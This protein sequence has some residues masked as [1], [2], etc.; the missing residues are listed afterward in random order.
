M[1]ITDLIPWRKRERRNIPVRVKQQQPTRTLQQ[2]F[3][4]L[5]DDLL[6]QFGLTPFGELETGVSAF[7]PRVDIVEDEKAIQVSVELPGV[8]EDDIDVA[9]SDDML[10]ISGEKR[11]EKE[12]R[13][14]SYYQLERS[15]GSFQR[16][17]PIPQPVDADE[18]KAVFK[19]G[20]LEIT[21]PK[22]EAAQSRKQIRIEGS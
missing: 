4:T 15:Y 6:E 2:D 21:L 17:V 12:T 3:N 22:E 20:V 8:D 10:T 5:F 13:E 1:S 11:E 19:H 9:F 18:V 14:K 16:I 7:T